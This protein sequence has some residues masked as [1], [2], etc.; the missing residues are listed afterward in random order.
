M[1]PIFQDMSNETG[2]SPLFF[3]ALSSYESAWLG[4]HAQSLHNPFGLTN[5][6]GNDLSF[7]SYANAEDYWMY[8]A[9]RTKDGYAGVVKGDNTISKF[10]E[11][12]KNAG[13]N[14]VNGDWSQKVIDQLTSITKWMKLCNVTM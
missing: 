10:A 8:G 4:S 6:G 14:N 2:V 11:D 9:G 12:L 13:Y 3:A 5:A 1:K 7:T